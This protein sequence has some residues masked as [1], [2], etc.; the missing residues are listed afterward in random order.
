[1]K[2]LTLNHD[3]TP[4]NLVEINDELESLLAI[5]DFDDKRLL[6]L[7]ERRDEIILTHL[8]SLDRQA[9]EEF[10]NAELKA[11]ETLTNIAKKFFRASLSKLSGLTR[12]LK[13]VEKYK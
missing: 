10:A 4:L 6:Q 1:M 12:G 9:R 11:N 3:K 2:K 13:A 7:V 8:D 5:D